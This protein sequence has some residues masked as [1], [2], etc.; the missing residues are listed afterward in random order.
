MYSVARRKIFTKNIHRWIEFLRDERRANLEQYFGKTQKDLTISLPST[1]RI[2]R[3]PAE[4]I[5]M[6]FYT[7]MVCFF[8]R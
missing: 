8:L 2:W 1:T 7:Q 4:G 5:F 3:V 6:D